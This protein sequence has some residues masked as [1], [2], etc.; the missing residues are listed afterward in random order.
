MLKRLF[1]YGLT[2]I[3]VGLVVWACRRAGLDADPRKPEPK[4]TVE[5]ARAFF[6]NQVLATKAG[7]GFGSRHDHPVGFSPGDFTPMWDRAVRAAANQ[8]VEGVDLPID[9]TFLFTASFPRVGRDGDTVYRTVDIVQKLV[10]NRWHDHPKWDG[11]YA[12]VATI[13]P[14]P[15]YYARHKNFGR[16][17]VNLGAKDDFAGVVVY[18]TLDG[19]FVNADKF[20]GGQVVDQVYNSD[21]NGVRPGALDEMMGDVMVM[22]GTISMYSNGCEIHVGELGDNCPDCKLIGEEVTVPGQGKRCGNCGQLTSRCVCWK[23]DVCSVC[24]R[25]TCICGS[26]K[27]PV[28][29]GTPPPG[30]GCIDCGNT[31][32]GGGG[33]NPGI[34]FPVINTRCV[35]NFAQNTKD[36]KATY[37]KIK[38]M[39]NFDKFMQM[40]NGQD[41]E[42]GMSLHYKPNEGF[43]LTEPKAGDET[44][45]GLETYPEQ[46]GYYTPAV[47]HSHTNE[48]PPSPQD[49]LAISAKQGS[50]PKLTD[51]YVVSQ[52]GGKRVVYVLHVENTDQ[53][54]QFG[55]NISTSVDGD[56][57]FK[58]G[59]QLR[60]SYDEVHNRM[61]GYSEADKRA[62]ALAHVLEKHNSGIRLLKLD[63]SDGT[64]VQMG[65]QLMAT[66]LNLQN[67]K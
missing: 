45:I 22:G 18:H 37:D 36:A 64:F 28:D 53:A 29:P 30:G 62:Y 14:T 51:A 58:T 32:G 15:E 6:E 55:N 23:P 19:C 11:M 39:P 49:V 27:P 34:R 13:I 48:G 65:I 10:V 59:S 52:D 16:K 46:L 12:Y 21:G 47:I 61:S 7:T 2:V 17:F 1:I 41:V 44:K 50:N 4:I 9:P 5:E 43:V 57:E 38:G 3:A 20:D 66:T 8:W 40:S 31:G 56:N 63:P 33:G 42:Y 67:C 24:G 60:T 25:S 54:Q 26:L 35:G